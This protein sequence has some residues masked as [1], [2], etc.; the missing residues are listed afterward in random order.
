MCLLYCDR[1][2]RPVANPFSAATSFPLR[3]P[4]AQRWKTGL[5]SPRPDDCIVFFYTSKRFLYFL[6][7]KIDFPRRIEMDSASHVNT[8]IQIVK[9]I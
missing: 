9:D 2:L 5:S 1:A 7:F 3:R 6:G 8:T 4:L